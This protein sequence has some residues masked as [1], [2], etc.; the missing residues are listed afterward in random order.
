MGMTEKQKEFVDIIYNN[1]KEYA[2]RY[3][4]KCYPVIIAQAIMES[5]WGTSYL[6]NKNNFFGLKCGRYWKGK[7]VNLLTKEEYIKGKLTTIKDDFRVYNTPADGVKGYCEFLMA[8]RYSNLKDIV[9]NTTY[10]TLLCKDGYANSSSYKRCILKLINTYDLNKY[11]YD[12]VK[13][14]DTV[15][16]SVL[17]GNWGNGEEKRKK[18]EAAGYDYHLVQ[19]RVNE[20]KDDMESW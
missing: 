11:S 13:D 5:G 6:A 9:D 10:V 8:S 14:I 18:L 20:L 12:S 1:L 3:N 2:P 16:L 15:A 7:S 4:L 17:R 19:S